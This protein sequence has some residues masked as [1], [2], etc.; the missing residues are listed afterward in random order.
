MNSFFELLQLSI[1]TREGLSEM[2]SAK[3]WEVLLEE[4]VRHGVA[5]IMY[6]VMQ[7]LY[8]EKSASIPKSIILQWSGNAIQ[9]KKANERV[10]KQCEKV[11][12][13]FRQAGFQAIVL[14]GQSNLANYPS[15]LRDY[16]VTGDI[17]VWV[18]G[19]CK[20]DV[21][22]FV[23]QLFPDE[24]Y[25]YVHIGFPVYSDIAVEIHLRPSY[26]CNPFHN[27]RL[28]AWFD[29]IDL[30]DLLDQDK[31]REFNAVFQ[32]LHIYKH[33]LRDGITM[34]QLLDYY[35]L[36]KFQPHQDKDLLDKLDLLSFCE[37]LNAVVMHLFEGKS[38]PT[39]S[40]KQ[41][42]DDIFIY[43]K[44][45]STPIEGIWKRI[46]HFSRTYSNEILWRPYYK[47]FHIFLQVK[48]KL[49]FA[50]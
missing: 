14:K 33:V 3:E 46:S 9:Y 18:K 13:H 38:L 17:D 44:S 16:R 43:G 41:L 34:K 5:G 39:P 45:G 49:P 26:L 2:P 35:F 20:E 4:A 10:S 27:H 42:L 11:L 48:H 6:P 47:L 40:S 24:I 32:P 15:H 12:A 25:R 50:S 19:K 8:N 21:Y 1:G 37:D 36:L 22:Q 29:S 28:Q 7:K 23:H 30:D 31:F